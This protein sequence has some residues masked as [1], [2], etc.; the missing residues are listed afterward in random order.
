M[1]RPTSGEALARLPIP[2]TGRSIQ[3]DVEALEANAALLAEGSYVARSAALDLIEY[4]LLD[5]I[6]L[7]LEAGGGSDLRALRRRAVAVMRR[8]QE[9]DEALFRE[10]RQQIRSGECRGQAFRRALEHHGLSTSVDPTPG[11]E[12]YDALD[13][14]VSS[15]L[16]CG[17]A[18]QAQRDL[19]PEMVSYQLTPARVVLDMAERAGIAAEDVFFDL[20]SGLGQVG[21]LVSL[22]TG[23]WARGVEREPAYC[24]YACQSVSMLSLSRVEFEN[25]D[26]REA[27]YSRGTVFYLYTPF[28]GRMLAGVLA[29]LRARAALGPITICTYGPCTLDVLRQEWLHP[30]DAEIEGDRRV[31]VFHSA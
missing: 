27:D 26:A 4:H 15:L 29:R 11:G 18:P 30:V 21:I 2:A 6:Q 12:E 19:E 14:F 25:G 22:I 8:L 23:A 1:A 31:A 28:Q 17:P 9:A 13:A 10:L 20:G 5:H 7:L 3:R 24:A 16:C